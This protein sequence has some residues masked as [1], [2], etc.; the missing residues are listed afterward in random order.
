MRWYNVSCQS[1]SAYS[2]PCIGLGQPTI[3]PTNCNGL[4]FLAS[5]LSY[6][7][8]QDAASASLARSNRAKDCRLNLRNGESKSFL[9]VDV[10]VGYIVMAMRKVT[11]GC[12]WPA[13][14]PW[15]GPWSSLVE[16]KLHTYWKLLNQ[17]TTN[18]SGSRKAPP[19]NQSA[20]FD[21]KDTEIPRVEWGWGA[22]L[23]LSG[24][25]TKTDSIHHIILV[26]TKTHGLVQKCMLACRL[27]M[28]GV[29]GPRQTIS[30]WT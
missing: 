28:R 22:V 20:Q 24:S 13:P 27:R 15:G 17:E 11:V 25:G 30:I 29:H 18:G 8:R 2:E 21:L 3:T 16:S 4:L 7:C 1:T 9:A 5:P 14:Y 26:H 19:N 10:E 23:M 6:S 12:S